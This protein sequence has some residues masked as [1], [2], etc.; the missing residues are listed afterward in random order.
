MVAWENIS[1]RDLSYE[2]VE[3]TLDQ[4]SRKKLYQAGSKVAWRG[5]EYEC[6]IDD[7]CNSENYHPGV[8][9]S[10]V[11]IPLLQSKCPKAAA[12]IMAETSK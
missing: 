9:D 2:E 4:Y 1:C 7:W 8:G 12:F 5:Q 6:I 10:G 11:W 3:T